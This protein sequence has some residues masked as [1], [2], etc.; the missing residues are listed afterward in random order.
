MPAKPIFGPHPLFFYTDKDSLVPTDQGAIVLLEVD[1]R[2]LVRRV[3]IFY[4]GTNDT[5]IA[6][7]N[8]ERLREKYGDQF[9][10]ARAITF[11]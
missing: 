6:S 5:E 8:N 2:E 4:R 7:G 11:E 9:Q 3:E 10:D 1:W